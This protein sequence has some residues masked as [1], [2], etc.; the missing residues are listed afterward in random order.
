MIN[1]HTK[2]ACCKASVLHFGQRRRQCKK[3]KKTW[4]VRKKKVGRKTRRGDASIIIKFLEHRT[5]TFS[6]LARVKGLPKS[7]FQ[8]RVSRMLDDFLL[9]TPWP[10]IPQKGPLI[11]VADGR[12]KYVEKGW[13]TGYFFFARMINEIEA[14]ILPPVWCPG[15]ETSTKWREVFE[16]LPQDI[17]SRIVALVC[18][19]HTGLVQEARRR[20]WLLQRC[21]AHL[22]KRI[23]S[24]R[25][26]WYSSRH[27][28]EGE[29][30]YTLVKKVL[31]DQ[32]GQELS[33]I[34]S[35][36]KEIAL[37]TSSRD[38]KN[39]LSGFINNYEDWRTYLKYP[40]LNLP[41]TNNTAESF[42]G[43]IHSLVHRARGFRSRLKLQKW[44]AALIKNKKTIKCR[45]NSQPS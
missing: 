20:G 11:L 39:T 1:K 41:T 33:V 14:T 25:S 45:G 4:R 10:S 15:T 18:D 9:K 3:C 21:H 37:N 17:L 40:N 36:L 6:H 43:C 42:S 38:L 7:T 24:R 29:E 23:Q 2:S 32:G 19:G 26:R 31:T 35:R 27:R 13:F 8:Y 22:I 16:N 5:S 28:P 30:I 34:L 12:V 44:V